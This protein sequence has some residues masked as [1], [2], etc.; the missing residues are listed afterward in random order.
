[1]IRIK[2]VGGVRVEVSDIYGVEINEWVGC[3]NGGCIIWC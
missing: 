3:G 1:M 2:D